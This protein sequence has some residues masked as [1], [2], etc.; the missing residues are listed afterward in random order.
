MVLVAV[1]L[2]RRAQLAMAP[3]KLCLV[4]GRVDCMLTMVGLSEDGIS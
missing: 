2:D 3:G 4:F 1:T